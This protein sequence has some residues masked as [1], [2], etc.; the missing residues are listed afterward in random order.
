M[1][2]RFKDVDPDVWRCDSNHD[3]SMAVLNSGDSFV[4]KPVVEFPLWRDALKQ[5]TTQMIATFNLVRNNFLLALDDETTPKKHHAE[6]D[7]PPPPP[8]SQVD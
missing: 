8:D 1:S 3:P 5:M 6:G 7:I 4:K 2:A